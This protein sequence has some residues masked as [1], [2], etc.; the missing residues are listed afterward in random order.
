VYIHGV[1]SACRLGGSRIGPLVRFQLS[2][3]FGVVRI[4][5]GGVI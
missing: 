3:L 2:R 4:D 1:A 5:V